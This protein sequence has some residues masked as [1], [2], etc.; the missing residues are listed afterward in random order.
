MDTVFVLDTGARML[1]R[2]PSLASTGP[3]AIV[4]G[5]HDFAVAYEKA[6]AGF[7]GARGNCPGR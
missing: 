4:P 1:Q 7:N 3:G 6:I 5:D 2:G